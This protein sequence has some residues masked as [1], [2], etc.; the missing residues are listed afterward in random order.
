MLV[1]NMAGRALIEVN[2]LVAEQLRRLPWQLTIEKEQ[3]QGDDLWWLTVTSP[4]LP[5]NC[6][7]H[8]ELVLTET[9]VQFKPWADV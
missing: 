7:G 1:R 4:R 2:G 5:D 6:A 3:Y 9:G 8:Q